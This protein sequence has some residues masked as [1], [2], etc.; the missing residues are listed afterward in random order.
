M[1]KLNHLQQRSIIAAKNQDWATAIESNQEILTIEPTNVGALNRL[2]VA[3]LQLGQKD[4]AKTQFERVLELD[5]SNTI[6]KKQ[7]EVLKSKKTPTLTFAREH[8]IEEP[9][10]TKVVELHR[11]A[12]KNVL[13]DLSLGDI[14]SLKSKNRY[15]SVETDQGYIGA[16]PEDLSFRLTKLM[17]NGNT[18]E[19]FIHS[20]NGTTCS[21]YLKETHRSKKNEN[22]NSF[23]LAKNA[24]GTLTD[25]DDRFLLE[26]DVPI[27]IVETDTDEEKTLDD[28][29]GSVED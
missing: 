25:L 12:S 2:G 14:C 8:F 5:K 21:V 26:E 11:L 23:P 16:L 19:C 24:A 22:I 18:Y 4:K 1:N 27:N 7:L 17:E 10:T 13:E 3:Q 29:S 20:I 9:G 15:I 28:V 6:A